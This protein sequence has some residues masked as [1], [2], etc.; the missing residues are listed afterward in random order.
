MK[1]FLTVLW[2]IAPLF[3][4]SQDFALPGATWHYSYEK[5]VFLV[6]YVKIQYAGDT[7]IQGIE[8]KKLLKT[9]SWKNLSTGDIQEDVFDGYEYVYSDAD[10]V[11]Q[12]FSNDFLGNEFKILYD[13]TVNTGDTIPVY[14]N[15]IFI[16][17][18]CNLLGKSVVTATGTEVIN[19]MELRWY[20]LEALPGT[21]FVLEGKIMERMGNVEGYLFSSVY[22]SIT[23]EERSPFRCYSDNEFPEYKNPDFEGDCNFITGINQ[24]DRKPFYFD[25]YPNPASDILYISVA[26]NTNIRSVRIYE[27]T[28]RKVL[29]KAGKENVSGAKTRIDISDLKAGMYLLEVESAGGIQWVER[30]MVR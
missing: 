21:G 9:L 11:Y 6:G 27:L 30:L 1:Y 22:C 14:N 12:F 24:I 26:E 5:N 18:E 29:E 13:F 3:G 28:G 7:V 10:H 2:M 8:A 4:I 20:S 19:G 17:P 16:I 23:E 25:F 15:E